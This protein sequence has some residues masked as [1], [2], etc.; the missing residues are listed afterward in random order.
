MLEGN[1]QVVEELVLDCTLGHSAV[2]IV[3]FLTPPVGVS[4]SV[5]ADCPTRLSK[6]LVVD[7]C[8]NGRSVLFDDVLSQLTLGEFGKDERM[9]FVHC[10]SSLVIGLPVLI[11]RDELL[12]VKR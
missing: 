12:L 6:C 11:M 10:S 1:L 5:Y 9:G 7:R 8:D 4:I 3:A 2:A